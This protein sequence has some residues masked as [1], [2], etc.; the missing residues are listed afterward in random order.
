MRK[1][2]HELIWSSFSLSATV[3]F[4]LYIY[5]DFKKC[6]NSTKCLKLKMIFCHDEP[7]LI[8]SVQSRC[9]GWLIRQND[10]QRVKNVRRALMVFAFCIKKYIYI[11]VVLLDN[12]VLVSCFQRQTLNTLIAL[13]IVCWY[14]NL[15][16][17]C[18]LSVCSFHPVKQNPGGTTFWWW[19]FPAGKP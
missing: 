1:L 8:W 14:L 3:Q 18:S 9:L 7:T 15:M 2:R 19:S 16:R 6:S 4:F 12:S 11:C 10:N 13:F 17:I 5:I